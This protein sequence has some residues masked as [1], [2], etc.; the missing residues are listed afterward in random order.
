VG[1]GLGFEEISDGRRMRRA[2]LE[3]YPEEEEEADRWVWHVS[4]AEGEVSYR[5]GLSRDGPWA[6]N[7]AGPKGFP[8][9][10]FLFSYFFLF[11]FSGFLNYF[12]EFAKMLQ[13]NSHEFLNS[14]NLLSNLLNQ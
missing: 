13:I 7:E 5:F 6:K 2:R 12:M 9:A 8:S 1:K 3:L 10:F 14:P 11:S 4:E